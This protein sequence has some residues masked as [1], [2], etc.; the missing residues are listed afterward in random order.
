MSASDTGDFLRLARSWLRIVAPPVTRRVGK[1]PFFDTRLSVGYRRRCCIKKRI[2]GNLDLTASI[3]EWQHLKSVLRASWLRIVAA[4]GI[5]FSKSVAAGAKFCFS[6]RELRL[7]F[8]LIGAL[9]LKLRS[10]FHKWKNCLLTISIN[11]EDCFPQ[12]YPSAVP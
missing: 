2:T 12:N 9:C 10:Q 8:F 6:G 11:G 1:Y 7:D 5:N 3:Q 4:S